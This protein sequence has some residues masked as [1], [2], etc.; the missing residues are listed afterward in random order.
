MKRCAESSVNA[1]YTLCGVA[2]DAPDDPM[3]KAEPFKFAAPGESV[4]CEECKNAIRTV[5]DSYPRGFKRVK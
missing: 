3:C 1:E 2:Y 4:T 5:R